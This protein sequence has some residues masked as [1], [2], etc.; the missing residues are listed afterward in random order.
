MDFNQTIL[1]PGN[2]TV[3]LVASW[4]RATGPRIFHRHAR[5]AAEEGYHVFVVARHQQNEIL[6]G[7]QIIA[8]PEIGSRLRRIL[9]TWKIALA[10]WGTKADLY[11]FYDL[12]LQPWGVLFKL[13][14]KRV[15]IDIFEDN[16]SAMLIKTWIPKRLRLLLATIVGAWEWT[17][18]HLWDGIITADPGVMHRFEWKPAHRRAVV[19]N[20]PRLSAFSGEPSIEAPYDIVYVGGLSVSRGT[21][22]LAR[23]V[24]ELRNWGHPCQVLLIGNYINPET[25][26]AM[27]NFLLEHGL[28][29]QFTFTGPL[30]YNEAMKYLSLAKVGVVP[31]EKGIQKY[32][33][34][35]P[36]KMFDYW[37]AGLP[38]VVTDF[39]SADSF[40]KQ[41]INGLV[42]PAGSVDKLADALRY[43]LTHPDEARRMGIVGRQ[44]VLDRWNADGPD[45]KE[46]M[47]LFK[48]IMS[49]KSG[50]KN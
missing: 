4:Y 6:E 47:K 17:T 13:L 40:I 7:I 45:N 42:V 33:N 41:G 31:F 49:S 34:N 28:A 9:S 50:R 36:S 37:A 26:C 22:L 30:P 8:Q 39:N 23:A 32:N 5:L 1:E 16:P 43:L 35:I 2:M 18:A 27:K 44:R 46:L 10:A 25:E 24:L 38:V 48:S 15:V 19:Y 11:V 12:E 21:L 20:F 29:D 14:N 3:C